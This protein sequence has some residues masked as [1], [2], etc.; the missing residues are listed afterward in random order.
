[1]VAP[2]PGDLDL[3]PWKAAVR[4]P[5]FGEDLPKTPAPAV[6][7]AAPRAAIRSKSFE[8]WAR[9]LRD[10]LV[11]GHTLV[12]WICERP[13]VSSRPG[14]TGAEFRARVALAARERRDAEIE[15]VRQDVAP[16]A[17]AI[18]AQIDAADGQVERGQAAVSQSRWSTAGSFG[19]AVLGVL[20]GRKIM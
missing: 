3:E 16:K 19:S 14:E 5:G 2:L 10:H 17:A 11:A 7:F 8:K 12:Q 13:Q 9:A 18:R 20:F 1:L 15:N 4:I 6:G